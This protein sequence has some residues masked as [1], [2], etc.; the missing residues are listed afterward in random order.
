MK[1]MLNPVQ[2]LK[3]TVVEQMKQTKNNNAL[4]A[5]QRHSGRAV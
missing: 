5:Q 3:L 1:W 4:L 2:F